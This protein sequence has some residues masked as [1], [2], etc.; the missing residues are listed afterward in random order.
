MVVNPGVPNQNPQTPQNNPAHPVQNPQRRVYR[1]AVVETTELAEKQARDDAGHAMTESLEDRQKGWFKRN[2]TRIWKHNLAEPFYRQKKYNESLKKILGTKNLHANEGGDAIVS[3]AMDALLERYTS[4]YRNE[5]LKDD[6]KQSLRSASPVG[7]AQVN[8]LIKTYASG[9]ID[10]A[11]F[12]RQKD[13]ILAG[14][15]ADHSSKEKLFTDNLLKIANEVKDKYTHSRNIADLDIDVELTLGKA[16]DRLNT[17]PEIQQFDRI[18]TK[19]RKTGLAAKLIKGVFG[20]EAGASLAGAAV[21]SAGKFF[22]NKVLRNKFAQMATFG[23]TGALAGVLAGRNE[24]ARLKRERSQHSRERA[25]GKNITDDMERR[26]EIEKFQYKTRGAREIIG[27]LEVN[28]ARIKSGNNTTLQIQ[29]ALKELSDIESRIKVGGQHKAD[30]VQYS[31]FDQVEQESLKIDLLR[32][33]LKDALGQSHP[34]YA[35]ELAILMNHNSDEMLRGAGGLE[36]KDKHFASMRRSKSWKKARNTFLFGT[37]ASVGVAEVTN[38]FNPNVDGVVSE[39]FKHFRSLARGHSW[40]GD[41][42]MG[43]HARGTPILALSRYL[44]HGKIHMP[45]GKGAEDF[46]CGNTHLKLPEG[47]Q[48]IENHDDTYSILGPDK[49]P[50]LDHAK[51]MF[52]PDGSIARDTQ[53]MLAGHGIYTSSPIITGGVENVSMKEYLSD[54]VHHQNFEKIHYGMW[55]ENGTKA[56]D[57]NELRTHWGGLHGNGIDANGHPI[58]N[59]GKMTSDGSWHVNPDGSMTQIDANALIKAGKAEALLAYTRDT[60]HD[61]VRIPIDTHGNLVPPAGKMADFDRFFEHDAHGQLVMDHGHPVPVG[62]FLSIAHQTGVGKDGRPI[63]EVMGTLVGKKGDFTVPVDTRIVNIRFDLE[64]PRDVDMPPFVWVNPRQP[65]ERLENPDEEPDIPMIPPPALPVGPNIPNVS[66]PYGYQYGADGK[67]KRFTSNW[68][69]YRNSNQS[70]QSLMAAIK[71]R[72]GRP[73]VPSTVSGSVPSTA[74]SN[75]SATSQMPYAYSYGTAGGQ[76][77]K[78]GSNWDTYRNSKSSVSQM[79]ADAKAPVA[80]SG[81]PKNY[82]FVFDYLNAIQD[83]KNADPK[84]KQIID[85]KREAY[86]RRYDANESLEDFL[87][88]EEGRIERQIENIAIEDSQVGEKPFPQE[89][90]DNAPMIK[91]MESAEEVAIFLDE[92]AIGDQVMMLPVIESLKRYFELNNSDKPIVMVTPYKA[93]FESLADQYKNVRILT[94]AEAKTFFESS[95]NTSR[96]VINASKTFEEYEQLGMTQD[97]AENPAKVLSIDWASWKAGDKEEYPVAPGKTTKYDMMPARTMRRFEIMLGQKLYENINEIDHYIEKGKNFD[98]EKQDLSSKYNIKPDEEVI[99]ISAGSSQMV[100]EYQP[101]K[102]REVISGIMIRNPKAHVLFLKDPDAARVARYQP[103]LDSMISAGS[104]ISV[105]SESMSKMNTLMGMS[106]YVI[107]PDTGLGHYAGA[108]GRKNIM[109]ILGDPVL[110]STPG[111][112]RVMHQKAREVYK[113]GQSTYGPA[114]SAAAQGKWFVE[115]NGTFVGASDITPEEVLETFDKLE[116]ERTATTP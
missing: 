72:G 39:G 13:Q 26:K 47:A 27:N 111:T 79:V 50:L 2:A 22:G 24:S 87:K 112:K 107:T 64:L 5:L 89:F 68:Q 10:Q 75:V 31:R 25:K 33:Q 12:E 85:Y 40:K 54:P 61:V 114:W 62:K 59:V 67:R 110:W 102:W 76:P 56:F 20:S 73:A 58:L 53:E 116:A 104:N 17:G 71:A 77:K 63:F 103:M 49:T 66:V 82:D 30:F 11:T 74:P 80:P 1:A 3:G 34:G 99:L 81:E 84:Q 23:A 95:K 93:L 44:T 57:E 42:N 52:N 70:M 60:Q 86:N 69:T 109:M 19:F 32:A 101:E 88:M 65:L 29:E 4:D 90:Y 115:D 98:S 37:L 91:G 9:R 113:K 36:E 105:V 41:P 100:K 51:L 55:H 35:G 94:Q 6:E 48:I 46:L 45:F 108:M 21:Y 16:R 7:N 43:L 38:A 97:D 18:W 96:Y 8:N 15:N 106:E 14:I 92:Q 28:L 78:F 83:Y